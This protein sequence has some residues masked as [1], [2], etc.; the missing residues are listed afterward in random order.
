MVLPGLQH[1]P[2]PSTGEGE[3][4][5]EGRW[6]TYATLLPPIP[7]F[8]RQ[9]EGIKQL[10]RISSVDMSR[11][12]QQ[13]REDS[14][15]IFAAGVAAV[16]PVAAVRR[17]VV[18]QGD[19]LYVDGVSYDLQRY[20]HVYVVGAGKAGATMAQGLE[21]VLGE[22]LTGGVVTVKYGHLAPVSRVTIHEAAH[23]VPDAAG[24][25]A[26]EAL[27][28]LAQQAGVDD[29][30]FCLFSGGG[31]ALLPAPSPGITL[32]EK[33]QVTSLLLEC[34]ASIDEINTIVKHMSKLKGGQLARLVLPATLITLVLSDVVG[35]R[36]DVIASGPTVPDPTTYQD[37]LEIVQR[38]GLLAR[39][40]VSVRTHLQRGQA[41]ELAETPKATDPAFARCQTVIIG[42]NRLALQAACA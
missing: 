17:A 5:G 21:E 24:M 36:L 11:T 14:R 19:T 12:I 25:R 7:T 33:Q 9:G 30:V 22:R 6:S 23:P 40:P 28:H 26:A 18:R 20:A 15:H 35:D 10:F 31:S 2:S 37:C 41:G 29:V 16:D 34:V 1:I 42:S 27:R 8:P 3:G 39:L 4:G 13:L 38:Y 32:E